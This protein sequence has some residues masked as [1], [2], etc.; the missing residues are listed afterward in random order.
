MCK[1]ALVTEGKLGLEALHRMRVPPL[2][3][4]YWTETSRVELGHDDT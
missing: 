2:V 1:R 3:V 4:L